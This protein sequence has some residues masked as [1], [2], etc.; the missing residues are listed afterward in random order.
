MRIFKNFLMMLTWM[1]ALALTL[2]GG[3]LTS[4]ILTGCQNEFFS[5]D[6]KIDFTL[7]S[8]PSDYPPLSRWQITLLAADFEKEFYLPA[9][10]KN[11]SLE[12]KRNEPVCLTASPL[13]LLSD[14][15]AVSSGNSANSRPETNFFKPAGSIY[16]YSAG[17]NVYSGNAECPLTWEEGFTAAVMQKIIR[18]SRKDGNSSQKIKSFLME[19]NWKKMNEKIQKNISDSIMSFE[20]PDEKS[21][22]KFYNPW[23]IDSSTLLDNLS[24]AVFESKYLNT[25]YIFTISKESAKIPAEAQIFSSF[26][27]ENQILQKYGFLTLK[28][29]TPQSYLLDNTYAISL[30]ATSAKNV[31][32]ALTY[33]PILIEDYEHPE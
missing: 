30:I 15:Q 21:K 8:W 25:I 14:R 22:A 19:F 24:F 27:P 7:P 18:S 28:K 17:G 31:S 5:D 16:P 3:L 26:I 13:T 6:E 1:V 33:M 20:N 32:A 10:A 12:L 4:G 11:F 2:A 9:E 23:Q 29:K